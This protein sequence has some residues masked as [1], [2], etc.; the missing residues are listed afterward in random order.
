MEMGERLLRRGVSVARRLRPWRLP[1]LVAVVT[2]ITQASRATGAL[3]YQRELVARGELWRLLTGNFIHLG[4]MHLARDLA[5]LALIWVYFGPMLRE[6]TWFALLLTSAL[7][8]TLGL[9]LLDPSIHWYVGLSGAL[10]GLFAA[11]AVAEWR[12]SR[13]RAVVMLAAMA[14]LLAYT[15]LIGPLPGEEA[16]LG[17]H[18]VVAA[19]VYGALSGL[20]FMLCLRGLPRRRLA[21]DIR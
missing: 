17:G 13:V 16:G 20:A 6:R 14:A 11:G 10:F 1:L 19:H 18:V 15:G 21:R 7:G 4:W 12:S 3:R 5:G 2:T 9:Y 8:S